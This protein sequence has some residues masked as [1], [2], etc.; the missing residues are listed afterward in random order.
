[1]CNNCIHKPVCGKF[2]ATGG[3]VRECEHYIMADDFEIQRKAYQ[4]I[5][6]YLLRKSENDTKCIENE[7][8]EG[9]NG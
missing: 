4:L 7:V 3:R 6:D 9:E 5:V 2:L 8:S 1:M